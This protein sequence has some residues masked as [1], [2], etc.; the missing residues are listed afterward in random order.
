MES[1]NEGKQNELFLLEEKKKVKK[2]INSKIIGLLKN[3][4]ETNPANE[5]KDCSEIQ[6][7]YTGIF[8]GLMHTIIGVIEH[9]Y[10]PGT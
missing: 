2:C 4:S 3:E 7:E 6:A 1:K 8:Q 9:H 10:M 5:T